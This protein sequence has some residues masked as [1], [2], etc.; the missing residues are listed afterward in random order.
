MIRKAVITMVIL[1]F[2]GN[3]F[4]QHHEDEESHHSNHHVAI[5]NGAVT[6]F[7]HET[8][9]YAVG[10]DYEYYFSDLL[11]AGLI[12]EYVFSGEG[13]L[14]LGIPLFIHPNNNIK[15]GIAPI[16][17]NAEVHHSDHHDSSHGD[18]YGDVDKEWN[19]GVRF[20]LAYNFHIGHV[21]TGPS[22]SLD[23]T[24]TT[25]VVYGFAFGIGF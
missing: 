4:A 10:F 7:D 3:L 25:A 12:G 22:V 24:N 15:F 23:V 16:W 8:T 17:I 19:M 20:N 6:N 21:S 18:T 5:F 14:L 1:F 11:A 9:G 13:E 2:Y